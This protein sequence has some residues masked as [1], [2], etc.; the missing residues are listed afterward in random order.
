MPNGAMGIGGETDHLLSPVGQRLVLAPA[1]YMAV[2]AAL[3]PLSIWK[4][5]VK[6]CDRH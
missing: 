5:T 6:D 1:L 4:T 2:G 3:P